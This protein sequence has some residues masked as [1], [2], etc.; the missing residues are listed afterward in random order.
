MREADIRPIPK[1]ILNKILKTD[2]KNY[3]TPDGHVRCYA[4]LTTWK[5]ELIKVTV[6]VKH[7]Y[8][9]R[10]CKQV[11]VHGL[12]SDICFVKDM[13]YCYCASMGFRFG[14][15]EE[16]LQKH[17]NWYE[18]GWCYADDKYYDPYAEIV[19]LDFIDRL[20]EFKYSEYK[21]YTGNNIFKY[22]R[23]YRKYPQLEILMK[24]GFTN[25]ALSKTI[26]RCCEDNA[27][28]KWLIVQRRELQ[29]K[30]YY[31]DVIARA[32]K[33]GKPLD[34]L[35]AYKEAKLQLI[36]DS[37]L[38]P[39]KETFKGKELER[40]VDYIAKQRTNAHTYLDYLKA[41][42]NLGLDMTEDKNRFPHDF[43]RWHDMR[44]DQYATKKAIEDEEKRKEL[45]TNFAKIADKYFP[46]QHFKRSAFICII[47]KSPAELIREGEALHHCVGRMNY[48]QRFV[49]EESLIF[50]VRDKDKPDIP[51]VTIEYSISQ[52]KVLQ[53][54]G[55]YDSK[56]SDDVLHYVNKVWLPHANKTI[57]QIRAAA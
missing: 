5:K 23:L 13:E 2:N 48:D 18:R 54:Y 22:L 43:K 27:F 19:N 41:C 30:Y 38:A 11:A 50:F 12:D 40:F 24:L 52:K 49:R 35:Q 20:P 15:Y 46:M 28:R 53:C 36:H 39:I 31:I 51:L 16:G 1:Y 55:E 3:P 57:K 26:L 10:Y 21:L 29:S 37:S 14:W 44:I 34:R 56:P 8:K 47:A 32:F 45:Y 9:K 25:I 33:T 17:R 7:R 42:Q 4:Y 6:V